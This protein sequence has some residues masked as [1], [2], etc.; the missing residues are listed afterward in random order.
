MNSN[1]VAKSRLLAF[2]VAIHCAV[3]SIAGAQSLPRVFILDARELLTAK[4]RLADPSLKDPALKASL[5]NIEKNA[6][7]ALAAEYASVVTKSVAPPNG[8]KHDYMSQAPYFWKNPK[9]KDGLPYIRRDGER[10]PEIEN[11]PDHALMDTMRKGVKR[12]AL[13]YYLTGNEEY[14]RKAADVLRM[15]FLAPAT[16]MNPN[17]E[18]AQWVPGLSKGRNFGIIESRGLTDVVDAI[19]LLGASPALTKADHDGLEKWFADYLDWLTKS[20]NGKAESR[21]ENNH[22]THYDCQV[23]AFALFVG[24]RAFAKQLLESAGERRIARQIEPD[25]RQPLELVRT[26][27]WSYSSMNLEGLVTLAV[28]GDAVGA[29]LWHFQTKDGRSIRKAIDF[30]YPYAA[31]EKKWPFEQIV[32]FNTDSFFSSMR[33]ARSRFPDAAFTNMMKIVPDAATEF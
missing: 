17:L 28:L 4:Q 22:G 30:L 21:A 8:D 18:F 25:G 20:E 7:S 1:L 24:R 9:T 33:R 15:W 13:A 2:I 26:R 16:R 5:R 10:N 12:L 32:A 11:F 3:A 19:G 31:G 29:D 27:S 14:A 6:K 23:A